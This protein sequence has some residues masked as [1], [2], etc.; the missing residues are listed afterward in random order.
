MRTPQVQLLGPENPD[1]QNAANNSNSN[2]V[3]MT[4]SH[5]A[6]SAPTNQIEKTQATE[7][8]ILPDAQAEAELEALAPVKKNAG[9]NF[10]E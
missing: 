5:D 6:G 1:A 3:E 7:D 8:N 10:L 9:F 4:D 2:E